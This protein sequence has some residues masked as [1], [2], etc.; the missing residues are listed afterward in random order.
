[1]AGNPRFPA[2]KSLTYKRY[3]TGTAPRKKKTNAR[4]KKK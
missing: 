3:E 4:K 1:M 2:L